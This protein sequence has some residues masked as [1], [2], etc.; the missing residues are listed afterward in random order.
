MSK[1]DEIEKAFL[2]NEFDIGFKIEK[3]IELVEQLEI[4]I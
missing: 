2:N 1:L 4:C 3:E